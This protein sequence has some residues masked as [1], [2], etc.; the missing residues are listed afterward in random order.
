MRHL[1][2]I[3]DGNRRWAVK[4]GMAKWFGH[5]EGAKVIQ[6]AIDFCLNKH[7]EFLSLYTFSMENI[8]RSDEEKKYLFDLLIS[9]SK[10]IVNDCLKKNVRVKFIGDKSLYPQ[11]VLE[12]VMQMEKITAQCTS[13]QVNFL[14]FYGSRQE[15]FWGIKELIKKIKTENL[16]DDA[17]NN[18]LFEQCLWTYGIPEPALIIRTGGRNRLSNFL[19]YQSAYSE[20][21]FLDC[22]WPEI[23]YT[24]FEQCLTNFETTQRNFGV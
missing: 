8:K 19:L 10:K 11:D 18:E 13:L 21:I 4:Q 2:V 6:Y 5:K 17:I 24:D 16:D 14:L 15:I 9:E 23:T 12:A 7:I 22:L 1:A 3:M 20:I